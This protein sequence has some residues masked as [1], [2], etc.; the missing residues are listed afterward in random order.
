LVYLYS[1]IKMM[2]GPIRIRYIIIPF[3]VVDM[4][5]SPYIVTCLPKLPT[6]DHFQLIKKISFDVMLDRIVRA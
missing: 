4:S 2:H 3:K 6:M 1:N 5:E